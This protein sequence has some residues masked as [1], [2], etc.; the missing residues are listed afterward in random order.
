MIEIS[1]RKTVENRVKD[2]KTNTLELFF[3]VVVVDVGFAV[4]VDEEDGFEVIVELLDGLIVVW[5]EFDESS[6]DSE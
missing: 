1:I 6:V 2:E 4:I 5:L 3:E